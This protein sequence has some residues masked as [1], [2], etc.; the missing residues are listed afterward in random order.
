MKL[1]NDQRTDAQ[2]ISG[3]N[4]SKK[5]GNKGPNDF[6]VKQVLILICTFCLSVFMLRLRT[7]HCI[8]G[9]ILTHELA[10]KFKVSDAL[11]KEK[12]CIRFALS[13]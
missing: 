2:P 11:P 13:H 3:P 6:R 8:P 4:R 12:L 7:Q 10:I 1:H 5:P 9:K